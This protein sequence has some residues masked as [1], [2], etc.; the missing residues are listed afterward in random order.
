MCSRF[1]DPEGSGRFRRAEGSLH[2]GATIPFLDARTILS[3]NVC[4]MKGSE[5]LRRLR[6]YARLND[7]TCHFVPERGKGSHGTIYLENRRTVIRNLKHELKAGTVHA[8][9]KQLGIEESD[10]S[11]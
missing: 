9:L 6:R 10:L 3:D 5:F 11:N 1:Q 2:V 8:M 4:K 7:M